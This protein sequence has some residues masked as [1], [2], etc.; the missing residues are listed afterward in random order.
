M[1]LAGTK[2]PEVDSV[3]TSGE[4]QQLLQAHGRE[5][6]DIPAAPLDPMVPGVHDSQQLYGLPGGSGNFQLT[7]MLGV[8]STCPIEAS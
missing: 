2:I 4:V 8:A 3:L 5:L 1:A 6:S 7:K